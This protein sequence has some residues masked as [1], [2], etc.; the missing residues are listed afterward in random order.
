MLRIEQLESRDNPSSPYPGFIPGWEGDVNLSSG[1]I[2]NNG[3]VDTIGMA[4]DG[5]SARLVVRSGGHLGLPDDPGSRP[6][7]IIV[8]EI[9]FDLDWRNGGI[10]AGVR[11]D[12]GRWAVAAT[13]A[14][15]GGPLVRV[16]A[17]TGPAFDHTTVAYDPDFRGGLD[18]TAVGVSGSLPFGQIAVWPLAGGGPIAK[19]LDPNTGTMVAFAVMN[20]GGVATPGGDVVAPIG[21]GFGFDPSG[22]VEGVYYGGSNPGDPVEFAPWI[23]A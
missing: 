1:D 19:L 23:E 4:G 16:K 8:N 5:G 7:D 21:A 17:F 10:P 2:D 13:P 9:W 22:T 11:L 3:T 18:L 12:D 6:G 14:V 15:G 20:P